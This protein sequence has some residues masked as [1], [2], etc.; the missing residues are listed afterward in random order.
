LVGEDW[1][2]VY[3]AYSKEWH[4]APPGSSPQYNPYTREWELVPHTIRRR[5]SR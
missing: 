3:N 4:F 5:P 1:V 2:L